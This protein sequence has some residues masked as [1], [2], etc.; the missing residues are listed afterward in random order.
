VCSA[1]PDNVTTLLLTVPV[2]IGITRHHRF[3]M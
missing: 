1:L 3:L 2:T